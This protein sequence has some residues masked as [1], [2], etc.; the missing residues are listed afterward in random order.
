MQKLLAEMVVVVVALAAFKAEPELEG[1]QHPV[2]EMLE[3][4]HLVLVLADLL[5]AEVEAEAEP[6][7]ELAPM[8]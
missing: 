1:N 3:D 5:E 6:L 2:K 4:Q 7:A 8:H